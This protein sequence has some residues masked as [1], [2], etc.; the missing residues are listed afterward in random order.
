[1]IWIIANFARFLNSA[2]RR[3]E[4]LMRDKVL[5]RM[6]QEVQDYRQYLASGKL[7]AGQILGEAYQLVVKQGLYF[8]FADHDCSRLSAREWGWLD[9]QEHITDYLF[10]LWM[11]STGL[12]EEFAEIIHNELNHDMEVHSHE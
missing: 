10:S 1:M 7:S 12:M 4:N 5:E 3:K 8:V 2:A 11:N 9:K 6:W